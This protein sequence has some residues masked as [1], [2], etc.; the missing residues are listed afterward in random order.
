MTN[1]VLCDFSELEI[2]ISRHYEVVALTEELTK[3]K[4]RFG[5]FL[6]Y[7]GLRSGKD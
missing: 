4:N 7:Q 6:G 2:Q 1:V 5:I 3:V